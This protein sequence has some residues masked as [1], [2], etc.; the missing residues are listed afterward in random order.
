MALAFRAGFALRAGFTFARAALR[1]TFFSFVLLR[2]GDFFRFAA[3][4]LHSLK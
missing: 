2:D 3:M 1:A 4:T